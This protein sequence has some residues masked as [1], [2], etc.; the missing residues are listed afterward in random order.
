MKAKL[1]FS[2]FLVLIFKLSSCL[3]QTNVIKSKARGFWD[4]L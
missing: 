2:V 3:D 4:V 1:I